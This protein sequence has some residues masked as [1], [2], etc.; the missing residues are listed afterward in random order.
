MRGRTRRMRIMRKG[1]GVRKRGLSRRSYMSPGRKLPKLIVLSKAAPRRYKGYLPKN[2]CWQADRHCGQ[3][4]EQPL[5]LTAR[6]P[7]FQTATAVRVPAARGP[8][9]NNDAF[10]HGQRRRTRFQ[11]HP[12]SPP[13]LAEPT[14][15]RR[16]AN[17]HHV[18]RASSHPNCPSTN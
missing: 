12:G 14:L 5:R 4:R 6:A 18:A 7:R 9:R 11:R 3:G 13:A 2:R 17:R 1:G 10:R 15:R 16:L 8:R